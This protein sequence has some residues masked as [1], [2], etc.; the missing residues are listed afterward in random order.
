MNG[1]SLI[2]LVT[3]VVYAFLLA[4]VVR[5]TRTRMR[6]LFLVYLIASVCW[7]LSSLMVLGNFVPGQLSLWAK[8]LPV[9]NREN[10]NISIGNSMSRLRYGREITKPLDPGKINRLNFMISITISKKN[11]ISQPN[12]PMYLL[13]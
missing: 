9:E 4:L 3:L 12:T 2:P 1:P 11:T 7:S 13:T 5:D 8:M 6:R 10:M